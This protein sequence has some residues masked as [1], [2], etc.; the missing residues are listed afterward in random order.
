MT[1]TETRP[2][3]RP[4]PTH[5]APVVGGWATT[6]DHK[7][8]GRHY[9]VTAVLF[10]L[11]AGLA[12]MVLRGEATES[13]IQFAGDDYGRL[14]SLHA[15]VAAVLFL[16]GLWAGLASAIVPLQIGSTRMAFARLH[17]ASYWMYLVGGVLLLVSYLID[18][19]PFGAGITLSRPMRPAEL[20]SGAATDLWITS[21]AL[22]AVAAILTAV[23]LVTT[24]LRL[25]APGLT[26]N[27]LPLFSWSVLCSAGV[28]ILATPVF[29]AGLLLLYL[30]QH[31]GGRFFARQTPGS[32]IVWQ[33]TLWLFGRPEIY[34][35]LLPGLGAAC[36]MVASHARRPLL[37][38]NA[39]Q[40]LI[41]AFAVL[42]FTAWA[43]GTV[44]A[45]AVVL[46]T[47]NW[48]TA[49]IA[50]PVVGL[51]LMWLGTLRF[52]RVRAHV[53]LLAV[54]AALVLLGF[55]TI[56]AIAAAVNEVDGGTAWS[57]GHLHVV[58]FGA[59]FVLA[60]GAV[61]HWS[62]KLF[63]RPAA[64]G[65]TALT[66]LLLLGGFL[67]MGL[68]DYLLGFDGAPWHTGELGEDDAWTGLSMLSA[69]GGA[70]IVLGALLFTGNVIGGL[71]GRRDGATD[72]ALPW[73][74][75]TLEWATPTPPPVH[76]FETVPEVRSAYPLHRD[77]ELA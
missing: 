20:G 64:Q 68:G 73:D 34:A 37:N 43:A 10:L 75:L 4:A 67:V 28:V 36:D 65:A 29:L 40:G 63:G 38:H 69:V 8:I 3:E 59:P 7:R 27:R 30:D 23:C 2:D 53:S 45:E 60:V 74:G 42:S 17:A 13:G 1:L 48:L 24:I 71:A 58:A 77:E 11:V 22:I 18:D 35:L 56:M 32:Q 50:L 76:N 15:T 14:F 19:G 70:L 25:R 61:N 49:L 31:F 66:I 12:G 5:S 51:E 39:A 54:A 52:G 41:G 9:L 16:P 21:L 33:H 26:V 55:G 57:T 44:E 6:A 46:P 47:Y 72:E 62:P